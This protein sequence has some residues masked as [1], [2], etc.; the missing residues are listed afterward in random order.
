MSDDWATVKPGAVKQE[1]EKVEFEIENSNEDNNQPIEATFEDN[2]VPQETKQGMV[3]EDE[4]KESGAQKRIRQLVRQRK[5]REAQIEE[6]QKR[7]Q[8][9]EIRLAKKEKEYNESL[10]DTL[11]SNERQIGDR[12]ELAKKAYR[13]AVES[14][15]ADQMLAAQEAMSSAQFEAAQIKQSKDAYNRYQAELEREAQRTSQTVAQ[16][17]ESYD[18]KAIAWAGRNQW[19]GQDQILTQAALQIDAGMKD[20]GF[21][22]ADDEY[23]SEIDRRLYAAFPNRFDAPQTEARQEAPKNA[24]QVV[25]GASRTPNPSSG[26]KV[27][28]SQ[29]DVRLAEKWGIPLEQ[30]AAEKLKVEKADGEYTD[31]YNKR[32]GY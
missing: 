9:L 7:Q 28:L 4:E 24:S 16:P 11:D 8:E 14:G 15:D 2:N 18:P 23:Y 31:I 22:P 25:A 10:K 1:E 20:E 21:D 29:E 32:G 13:Q 5:E 12:L 17:A 6:L 3:E 19:F 30:Y 27:R 26:R